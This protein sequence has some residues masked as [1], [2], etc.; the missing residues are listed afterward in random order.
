MRK[1]PSQR[2]TERAGDAK[3]P[4]RLKMKDLERATFTLGEIDR[5]VQ[6]NVS[7]S[8]KLSLNNKNGR[9]GRSPE[10]DELRFAGHYFRDDQRFEVTARGR[11]GRR[12][13]RNGEKVLA[14]VLPS[15]PTWARVVDE[16]LATALGWYR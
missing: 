7:G 11:P 4:A 16:E 12:P 10:S 15:Q 3:R 9:F 8:D 13:V 1:I 5:V 6:R 14:A 2:D